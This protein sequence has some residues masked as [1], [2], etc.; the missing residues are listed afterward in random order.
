MIMTCGARAARRGRLRTLLSALPVGVAVMCAPEVV[1][2]QTIKG[3]H[4]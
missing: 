3:R 2:A 1:E 4:P